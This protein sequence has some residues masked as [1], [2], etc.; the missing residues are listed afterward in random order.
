MNFA[1]RRKGRTFLFEA[2]TRTF[3]R[4]TPENPRWFL[5]A[6]NPPE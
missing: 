1:A 3:V 6:S 2:A 4:M 5:L